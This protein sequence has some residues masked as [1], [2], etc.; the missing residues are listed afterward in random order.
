MDVSL[1][2][3]SPIKRPSVK[4]KIPSPAKKDSDLLLAFSPVVPEIKAAFE[5]KTAWHA[6]KPHGE[7][8][9]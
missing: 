7:K 5:N 6:A 9:R 8:M 3:G 2:K 4:G 1:E